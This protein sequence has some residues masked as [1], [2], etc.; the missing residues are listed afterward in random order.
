M[1]HPARIIHGYRPAGGFCLHAGP[2]CV[3]TAMPV[4]KPWLRLVH[5]AD[6]VR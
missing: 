2:P 1:Y 3:H 4:R 5:N 6:K